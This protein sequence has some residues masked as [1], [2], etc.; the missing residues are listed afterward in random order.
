MPGPA[1]LGDPPAATE[2][3]DVLVPVLHRPRNVA[4][5][6]ASLRASTSLATAW[7]ICDPDDVVEQEEVRRHG[8]KILQAYGSFGQKVNFAWRTLDK[9]APWTFIVGDDVL[10]HEGWLDHAQ[11]EAHRRGLAVCATNDLANWRVM[12]GQQGTHLLIDSRYIEERGASWDGPGVICHEGYRHWY[13]DTEIVDVAKQRD[14]FGVALT[15]VVEHL[16]PM[17]GKA[18]HDAVYELG[19]QRKDADRQ[20]YRR[21]SRKYGDVSVRERLREVTVLR[22]LWRGVRRLR[23]A[24]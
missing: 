22:T 21:R 18:E 3:V 9:H 20:L 15:S 24:R 6:M 14:T 10:F 17:T 19:E 5:F 4:P 16:H 12:A 11:H 8:G 13:V 2:R 23:A 7:F 1:D